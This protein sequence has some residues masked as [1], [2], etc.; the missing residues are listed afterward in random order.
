MWLRQRSSNQMSP[1]RFCSLV[2][3][4]NEYVMVSE[5]GM[6]VL[7]RGDLGDSPDFVVEGFR[8]GREQIP[9]CFRWVNGRC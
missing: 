4:S 7:N 2:D 3:G 8:S 6:E 9:C 5:V 1:G